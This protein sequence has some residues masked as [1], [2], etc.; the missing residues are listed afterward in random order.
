MNLIGS[1]N[2]VWESGNKSMT[3]FYL[4]KVVILNTFIFI[5]LMIEL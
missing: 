5:K 4:F 3:E 2:K 1:T